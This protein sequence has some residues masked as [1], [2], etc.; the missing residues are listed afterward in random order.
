MSQQAIQLLSALLDELNAN[1]QQLEAEIEAIGPRCWLHGRTYKVA[2]RD[3][4]QSMRDRI[5]RLIRDL[6]KEA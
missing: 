1:I 3:E 5:Y 2:R 4:A 6:E